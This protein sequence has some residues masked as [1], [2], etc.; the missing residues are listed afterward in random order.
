M[1]QVLLLFCII[2]T[3]LIAFSQEKKSAASNA[4]QAGQTKA[5]SEKQINPGH[6]VAN[7][8][9]INPAHKEPV[10]DPAN[11]PIETDSVSRMKK[12]ADKGDKRDYQLFLNAQKRTQSKDAMKNEK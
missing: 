8:N 5:K 9:K 11:H 2:V 7:G 1:K 6:V 4:K 3:S 12:R 10:F